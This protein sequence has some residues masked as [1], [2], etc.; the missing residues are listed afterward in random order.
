M[1]LDTVI[2]KSHCN[3]AV[4]FSCSEYSMQLNASRIKV[5]QAQDDVVNSMKDA[6]SKELLNVSGDHHVYKRLLKELIVQVSNPRFHIYIFKMVWLSGF[7][8]H[9]FQTLNINPEWRVQ[10]TWS[11]YLQMFC[12]IFV[13]DM[14]ERV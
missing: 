6:A 14:T 7:C 8:L 11:A 3:K 13:I 10:G 5:L 12:I 4:I 2:D 9:A 1:I